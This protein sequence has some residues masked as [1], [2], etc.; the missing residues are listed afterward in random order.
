MSYE[1]MSREELESEL[2]ELEEELDSVREEKEEWE[3]KAK[4]FKADFENY[5]KE[6][7]DRKEEWKK[8]AEQ[9]L[10]EDL[11]SI[12]DN[13]ERAIASADE[14]T[15]L[16]KGVKMVSDQ[17]IETLEKKG[18]EQINAEGEEFDPEFHK[19][20]DTETHEEHNKVIEQRRKGYMYGDN[21]LRE[22]EVI[23]GKKED[24]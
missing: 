6:E 3:E 2:K 9:K 8:Q 10:A 11:I 14:E 17:L 24:Q 21:L 16:L 20:I 18:L 5:K 1:D 22:A 13:L 23:V 12:I 7:E 4:R 15:N 19:A